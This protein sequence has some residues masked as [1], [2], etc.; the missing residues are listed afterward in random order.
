MK[1][2]K[3]DRWELANADCVE[4]VS[5]L[6]D[7]SV[8]LVCYS[9]P[10]ESLFA[11]S[12]DPR[13][14]SNCSSRDSCAAGRTRGV[15]ADGTRHQFVALRRTSMKLRIGILAFVIVHATSSKFFESSKTSLLPWGSFS[16]NRGS[17][18]AR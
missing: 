10:F 4:F 2:E 14:M 3:G 6:P 13:D 11:Y 12:D 7:E 16:V 8:D 9:P 15:V 1:I 5:S 18:R 17:I